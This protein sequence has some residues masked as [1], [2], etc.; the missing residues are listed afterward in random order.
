MLKLIVEIIYLGT[1]NGSNN[2]IYS[3]HTVCSCC[4]LW[5]TGFYYI[6]LSK[7]EIIKFLIQTL[8]MYKSSSF[9]TSDKMSGWE[10]EADKNCLFIY[11][12]VWPFPHEKKY[13]GWIL[14]C[15]TIN[16]NDDDVSQEYLRVGGS[17]PHQKIISS[18]CTHTRR[19]LN[20]PSP[21]SI[22]LSKTKLHGSFST[23]W[24]WW[25]NVCSCV[26]CY[27]LHRLVNLKL[28]YQPKVNNFI[29][30]RLLCYLD[31]QVSAFLTF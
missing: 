22:K 17:G 4:F 3:S 15:V 8:N 1:I 6:L 30:D 29:W 18:T 9:L 25:I 24:I 2:P 20:E 5:Q 21:K 31:I 28:N 23:W 19:K 26:G 13:W 27:W 14:D 10:E 11:F 7:I 16:D 12:S